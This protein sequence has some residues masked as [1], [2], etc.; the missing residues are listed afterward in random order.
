MVLWVVRHGRQGQFENY[1]LENDIVT[2]DWRTLPDMSDIGD[3]RELKEH[4]L[5]VYPNK[6][7]ETISNWAGQIRSFL[8]R[9][10][11]GELVVIP[12]RTE[13]AIAVGEILS[14]YEYRNEFPEGMHHTRRVKW[15]AK[16]IPKPVVPKDILQ[17]FSSHMTV[18]RVRRPN[19][20]ERVRRLVTGNGAEVET[21][22][23]TDEEMDA[24]TELDVEEYVR[25]EIVQF[26]S[27]RF[28]GH[29]LARLVAGI[30]T[31]K[32]YSVHVSPPGSDGG[33]DIR[34]VRGLLGFD[35]PRMVVQVKSGKSQVGEPTVRE[36]R[37][38]I[39]KGAEC[40]LIVSWSGFKRGVRSKTQEDFFE[41]R[42]WDAGDLVVELLDSYDNMPD[43]LKAEV[44]LKRIWK[45]VDEEEQ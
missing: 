42:Y 25:N 41:I 11:V 40:G 26:I 10:Q 24:S 33:V 2:I 34:A 5:S 8:M 22:D 31:A 27:E 12:L 14:S 9:M 30:L 13:S 35:S 28:V 29:E 21:L 3:K 4:I 7:R 39:N 15:L 43:D 44:P 6:K 23:E 38:T 1:A 17:S 36:L 20:V 32:G 19:A 16:S 45:L 18:F 37:G